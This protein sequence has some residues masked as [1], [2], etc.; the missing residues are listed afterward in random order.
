MIG[1]PDNDGYSGGRMFDGKIGWAAH[2]NKILT[3][4]QI[5]STFNNMKSRFGL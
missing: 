1:G 2:Y 4:V 3:D 5:L